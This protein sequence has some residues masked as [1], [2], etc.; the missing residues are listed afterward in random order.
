MIV[1]GIDW[2]GDPGMSRGASSL[3]AFAIVHCNE[4]ELPDVDTALA[5]ARLRLGLPANY[6]FK[7]QA[8]ALRTEAAVFAAIAELPI[9]VHVRLI[10][11]SAIG[12]RPMTPAWGKERIR[13]HVAELV[14]AC[15]DRL[16]ADQSLRIDLPRSELRE[17]TLISTEMRRRL[18]AAGRASF[19]KVRPCP[20]D[21]VDGA[22]I[23]LADM[24]AGEARERAGLHGPFLPSLTSRIQLV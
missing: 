8:A 6:V 11:K 14:E 19:G 23:Q 12:S 20:D 9:S 18:R 13:M 22:I 5:L 16:V 15:P 17:I 21:S 4:H 24:V 7:Y 1:S 2:S 3:M 10:D